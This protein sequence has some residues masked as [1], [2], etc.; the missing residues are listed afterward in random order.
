MSYQLTATTGDTAHADTI[1]EITKAARRILVANA[2]NGMTSISITTPEGL[3]YPFGQHLDQD[4]EPAA[5][6]YAVD[7][8]I[9]DIRATMHWDQDERHGR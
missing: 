4:T 1:A 2:G 8:L 5:V 6:K 3:E 9:Y 7:E